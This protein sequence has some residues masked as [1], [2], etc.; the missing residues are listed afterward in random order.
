VSILLVMLCSR[1]GR[2]QPKVNPLFIPDSVRA[3]TAAAGAIAVRQPV[4]VAGM[5]SAGKYM[6]LWD[7]LSLP[8][9]EKVALQDKAEPVDPDTLPGVE[10]RAPVRSDRENY[11]EF[12]SYNYLLVLARKTP[13]KA[14]ARGAR[15]DVTYAHLW[16]E[17]SKYRGQIIHVA[18]RLKRLRK[19]DASRIAVKEGVP[20]L[21]EAWVFE[22]Q[23][24][25]NP[26]CVIVSELPRSIRVGDTVDYQVAFD[27]YFFKRYRYQAGDTVRD[28][29][30]L[31]GR[32]L[33]VLA[34]APPTAVEET[35]P[36]LMKAFIGVLG[37]TALLVLA[38]TYWFLRGDRRVRA[39]LDAAR[40]AG[41]IDPGDSDDRSDAR[42]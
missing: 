22:E 35:G 41:F 27:G 13:E 33:T 16:E 25:H 36:M 37:V 19:F 39:R 21:Y 6:E 26:Y 20:V 8:P 17:P 24:Y 14:L 12:L 32:T 30:L 1:I 2:A 23:Y 3:A 28:A 34:G 29:P 4:G 9:A 7:T 31:I 10:D 38:L 11:N 15:R 42:S 18:G 40:S 5:I